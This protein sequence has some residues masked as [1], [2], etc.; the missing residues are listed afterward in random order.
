MFLDEVK[1]N[2]KPIFINYVPGAIGPIKDGILPKEIAKKSIDEKK[3]IFKQ[4]KGVNLLESYLIESEEGIL[5]VGGELT[6]D[7]DFVLTQRVGPAYYEGWRHT[8]PTEVRIGEY[9]V[10]LLSLATNVWDFFGLEVVSAL[11]ASGKKAYYGPSIE[12]MNKYLRIQ[13]IKKALSKSKLLIFENFESTPDRIQLMTKFY[14]PVLIKEKTGIEIGYYP[15]EQLREAI[16]EISDEEGEKVAN[17]WFNGATSVRTL[18]RE[19][20]LDKKYRID[21]G[22]LD[23]VIRKAIKTQKATAIAGCISDVTPGHAPACLTL[24]WLKDEGIPAACQADITAAL[25]MIM[26]MFIAE[27]PADM[28]NILINTGAEH[29]M[30]WEVPNPDGNTIC[31]SHSVVPRK[32]K[33]FDSKPDE[34]EICGTHCSTC[35]G[36]NHVTHIETGG[37]ATIARMGPKCEKLL[38]TKGKVT[39]S[40]FTPAQ[41]N[42]QVTYIDLGKNISG[43]LEK[44]APNLGEHLTWVFGDHVEE[45]SLLCKELGIEPV[46]F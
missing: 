14:D 16:K 41:G 9:N 34:Y 11:T 31:I 12:K 45:M 27:A 33:G 36:A 32:M 19:N 25:P 18:Y 1:V 44:Y 30:D 3:N 10:P 24:T 13:Q 26:L 43:F 39:K 7:V 20:E 22:K 38:L 23:L 15:T 35:F 29:M 8:T 42:R 40:I 6:K 17:V 21:L 2:V 46:I 5:K 4:L 28:G 37:M